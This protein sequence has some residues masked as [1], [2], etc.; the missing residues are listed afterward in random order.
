MTT[1]LMETF[2]Q[3]REVETVSFSSYTMYLT[4]FSI[5]PHH[6]LSDGFWLGISGTHTTESPLDSV[7]SVFSH[8]LD[9]LT[10]LNH[11]MKEPLTYW[12][13]TSSIVFSDFI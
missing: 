13:R 12:L 5:S 1:L 4:L 3:L 8:S 6:G 9:S 7:G 10:K 2:F 11:G